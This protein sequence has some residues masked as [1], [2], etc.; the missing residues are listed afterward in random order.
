MCP[1]RRLSTT[2]CPSCGARG[3]QARKDGHRYDGAGL[4]YP[5]PDCGTTARRG[6][7][8]AA[9]DRFL[10]VLSRLDEDELEG[11]LVQLEERARLLDP[12]GRPEMAQE[13][14]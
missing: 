11:Q 4:D 14:L 7:L 13:V 5:C 6:R 10:D 1:N 12:E 2:P 3:P 9:L 8:N